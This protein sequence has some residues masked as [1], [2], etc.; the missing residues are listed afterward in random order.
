[1]SCQFVKVS[2]ETEKSI[3]VFLFVCQGLVNGISEC[4]YKCDDTLTKLGLTSVE[5]LC[6]T[7]LLEFS[8][9]IAELLLRSG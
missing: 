5:E 6:V 7:S 4:E 1:M 3:F 8:K 2:G 9:G